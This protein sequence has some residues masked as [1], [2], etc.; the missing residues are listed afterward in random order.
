MKVA[1]NLL[2]AVFF[3]LRKTENEDTIFSKDVNY[4]L[5]DFFTFVH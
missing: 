5:K 2:T 3:W 1:Q 4:F